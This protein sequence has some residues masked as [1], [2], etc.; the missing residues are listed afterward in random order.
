MPGR[1]VDTGKAKGKCPKCRHYVL[2]KEGERP[3]CALGYCAI[4]RKKLEEEFGS[5]LQGIKRLWP[6]CK[7]TGT[8]DLWEAAE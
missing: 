5:P 2:Y 3:G 6:D 4:E 1:M 7:K 8:C